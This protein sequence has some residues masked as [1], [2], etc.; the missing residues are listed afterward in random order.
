VAYPRHSAGPRCTPLSV[1]LDQRARNKHQLLFIV[2]PG[3]KQP[4][5]LQPFLHPIAKELNELAK[6]VLGLIIS[7]STLPVTLRAEV[8]NFS[9]DQHEGGK[10]FQSTGASSYVYIRL[11][12]F[13][14]VFVSASSH[15][16]P[17]DGCF[18]R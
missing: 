2:T 4:V 3:P 7:S 18:K 10:L 11:R 1:S 6:D 16:L 13:E 12:L 17:A 8:L 14:G 5:D 15:F 9:T